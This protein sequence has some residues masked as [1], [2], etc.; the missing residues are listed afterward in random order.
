MRS[1]ELLLLSSIKTRQISF[2]DTSSKSILSKT[3]FLKRLE[4]KLTFSKQ[5]HK[6]CLKFW[7]HK[8]KFERRTMHLGNGQ[9][10]FW[11]T[12]SFSFVLYCPKMHK[13]RST[14]LKIFHWA[15]FEKKI[16]KLTILYLFLHIEFTG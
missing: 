3:K 2:F 12:V 13:P 7:I 4:K 6:N 1:L 8:I 5:F 10:D 9:D 11:I 15:L 16:L 14:H